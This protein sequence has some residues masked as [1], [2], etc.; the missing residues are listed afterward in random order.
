MQSKARFLGHSLHQQLVVFPLGLLGASVLFDVI[1]VAS[2]STEAAI[3]A[4]WVLGTGLA[5]ALLAAPFG[6]VDWLAIPGGTRAKRIG[7]LHGGT[8]LLV[9]ALFALSWWLRWNDESDDPSQAAF[10]V[11]LAA[12]ALALLAAWFGGELVARLG[13]GVHDDAHLDAPS[14]LDRDVPQ[15]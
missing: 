3:V 4:F 12:V 8:N 7:A 13:V 6:T 11:S 15:R 14:S 5:G 1:H 9:V 2:G 10:V